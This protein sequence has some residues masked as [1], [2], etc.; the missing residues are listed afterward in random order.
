MLRVPHSQTTHSPYTLP[1]DYYAF[2]AVIRKYLADHKAAKT[3]ATSASAP[4]TEADVLDSMLGYLRRRSQAGP[5]SSASGDAPIREL[6]VYVD[7]GK[8]FL[9]NLLTQNGVRTAL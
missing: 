8:A 2:K 9:D 7:S 5:L 3:P 6:L 1:V 4:M